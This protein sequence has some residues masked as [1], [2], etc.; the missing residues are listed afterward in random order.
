[1]ELKRLWSSFLRYLAAV[2]SSV[3]T[4]LDYS[5][6]LTD[7]LLLLDKFVISGKIYV[8][9]NVPENLRFC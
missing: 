7:V 8:G 3:F 1:M 4:A 2:C 6:N 9:R 5:Y